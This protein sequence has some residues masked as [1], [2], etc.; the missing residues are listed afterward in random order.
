LSLI[1]IISK[2]ARVKGRGTPVRHTGIFVPNTTQV[3]Y[4][5]VSTDF[6]AVEGV[7]PGDEVEIPAGTYDY[8]E[9]H[10]IKGVTFVVTG[11]QAIFNSFSCKVGSEDIVIDGV[12]ESGVTYGIKTNGAGSF[13]ALM[14]TVGR[15]TIKGWDSDGNAMGIQVSHNPT[16]TYTRNYCRLIIEDSRF[17]NT[18]DEG[19]GLYI[20]HDTLST[21]VLIDARIRHNIIYN[22]GRD[23]IQFRNGFAVIHNNSIIGT[24]R[25]GNTAHAHGILIGGNTNGSFV[26]DNT[27]SSIAGNA[28]FINGSGEIVCTNNTLTCTGVDPLYGIYVNNY[29]SDTA[30]LQGVNYVKVYMI[31][32]NINPT[33]SNYWFVTNVDT[34]KDPVSVYFSGNTMNGKVNFL[35]AGTTTLGSADYTPFVE[36]WAYTYN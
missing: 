4:Y 15:L 23:G 7:N 28:I 25:A 1:N 29:T 32:N 26:Y 11:G 27:G 21:E 35:E 36:T 13:A 33:N 24:G 6:N 17:Q 30:D 12:S 34:G 19:E 9:A 16:E 8:F 31:N 5:G 22:C 14:Q 2:E 3:L 18:G 10:I 20:G